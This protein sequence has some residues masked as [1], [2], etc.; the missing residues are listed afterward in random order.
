MNFEKLIP[1]NNKPA[2]ALFEHNITEFHQE[3]PW[4]RQLL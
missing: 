2:A 4:W 3:R 1:Y